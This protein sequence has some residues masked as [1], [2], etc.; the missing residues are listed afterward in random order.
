MYK[1]K[2]NYK[3]FISKFDHK[4]LWNLPPPEGSQKGHLKKFKKKKSMKQ[5]ERVV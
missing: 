3:L 5:S 2:I 4:T 1:I